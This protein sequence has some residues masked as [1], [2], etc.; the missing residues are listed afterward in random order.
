MTEGSWCKEGG[1]DIGNHALICLLEWRIFWSEKAVIVQAVWLWC[2]EMG[3]FLKGQEQKGTP[4]GTK[5]TSGQE[6]KCKVYPWRN[7]L[8][9]FLPDLFSSCVRDH[10]TSKIPIT[11]KTGCTS[12]LQTSISA[13][14]HYISHSINT[15]NA[16]NKT[17]KERM[18]V[19]KG[20]KE[21]TRAAGLCCITAPPPDCHHHSSS[22]FPCAFPGLSLQ[23]SLRARQ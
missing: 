4:V 5:G 14:L 6:E 1:G 15:T 3:P 12:L 23:Q 19:S 11:C 21:K 18:G 8:E 16:K 17:S 2:V 13:S 10:P 9:G 7:I 20:H 22:P